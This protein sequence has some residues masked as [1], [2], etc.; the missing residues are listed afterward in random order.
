M[1]FPK[2]CST[3]LLCP[4]AAVWLQ[5]FVTSQVDAIDLLVSWLWLAGLLGL[6]SP[7]GVQ[8]SRQLMHCVRLLFINLQVS[9]SFPVAIC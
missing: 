4:T 6:V 7:T 2:V 3:K 5:S 9:L 1:Q 8:E